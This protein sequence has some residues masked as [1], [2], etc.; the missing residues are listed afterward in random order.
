MAPL[1]S[2]RP[3]HRPRGWLELVNQ[4]QTVVEEGLVTTSIDRSR[5]LGSTQWVQRNAE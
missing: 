2:D 3:V 1:L 5:P 4:P